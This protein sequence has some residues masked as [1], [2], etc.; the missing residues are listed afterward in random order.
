VL[1]HPQ[2]SYRHSQ[3]MGSGSASNHLQINKANSTGGANS[4]VSEYKTFT[5]NFFS[6]QSSQN[7]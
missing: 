1:P 5:K 3:N 4:I 7:M 6:K 2:K